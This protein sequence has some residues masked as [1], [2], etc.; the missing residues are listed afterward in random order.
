MTLADRIIAGETVHVQ[1]VDSGLRFTITSKRFAGVRGYAVIPA[2]RNRPL[3]GHSILSK[4]Q[5]H[6]WAAGLVEGGAE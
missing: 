3:R 2:G 1:T 6:D 5:V 4:S